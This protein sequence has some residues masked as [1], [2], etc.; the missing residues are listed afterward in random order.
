MKDAME[1]GYAR[2]YYVHLSETDYQKRKN[3]GQLTLFYSLVVDWIEADL[4]AG[5]QSIVRKGLGLNG[6]PFHWNTEL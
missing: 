4:N 2:L 3:V 6:L 1:S 5:L